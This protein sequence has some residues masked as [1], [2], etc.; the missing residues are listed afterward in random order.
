M[1]DVTIEP[2]DGPMATRL[3]AAWAAVVAVATVLYSRAT[4]PAPDPKPITA[5]GMLAGKL[6]QPV[7]LV[8]VAVGLGIVLPTW[9]FLI[10]LGVGLVVWGT[11]REA[12]RV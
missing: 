9:A 4:A 10:T 1:S 11:L 12:G 7:G 6:A 2:T 8:L 5:G 3:L